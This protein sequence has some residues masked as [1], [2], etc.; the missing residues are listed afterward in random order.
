[1]VSGLGPQAPEPHPD[2]PAVPPGQADEL[3]PADVHRLH[4]HP[5]VQQALFQPLLDL[6]GG[7]AVDVEPHQGVPG[8]E[9]RDLSGEV[10]HA[11][12]LPGADGDVS[13]QLSLLPLELLL[14]LF[15]QLHDL[16]G[17]AAQ[18]H[19]VLGEGHVVFPPAE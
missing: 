7:G 15:R 6:V 18:E 13:G 8:A 11:V 2:A 14:C 19:P 16:L 9:G 17:P 12:A 10:R 4:E 1:M 5:Q 3:V